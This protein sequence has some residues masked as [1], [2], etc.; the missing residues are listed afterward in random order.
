MKRIEA[1]ILTLLDDF[2]VI[3]LILIVLPF[4]GIQIPVWLIASILPALLIFSMITYKAL[5]A[6][7]KKPVMGLETIIGSIGEALTEINGKGLVLLNNELWSAR[8]VS[9]KIP[10]G[11]KVL[12][13]NVEG[14]I[15][16]VEEIKKS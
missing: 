16:L 15:L 11:S 9:K 3:A 1:T 5:R 12:I 13:K 2:L 8:S 6:L 4:L 14:T 10:K 7:E